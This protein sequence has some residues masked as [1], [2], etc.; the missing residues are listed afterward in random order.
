MR[1]ESGLGVVLIWVN[2]CICVKGVRV[3]VEVAG[4]GGRI[5]GVVPLEASLPQ[6]DKWLTLA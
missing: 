2:G 5:E 4:G 6:I 1:G 3:G